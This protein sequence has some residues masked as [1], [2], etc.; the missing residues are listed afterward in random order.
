MQIT[1]ELLGPDMDFT[2]QTYAK[3]F[4]FFR[5]YTSTELVGG[6]KVSTESPKAIHNLGS[7]RACLLW[8]SNPRT[9]TKGRQ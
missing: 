5:R 9:S 8:G 1:Q 6:V 2:L 7:Q 4:F 3:Q